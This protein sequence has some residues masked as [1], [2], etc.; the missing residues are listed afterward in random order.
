MQLK[1]WI[2]LLGAVVGTGGTAGLYFGLGVGW[3]SL[4]IVVA[5]V[6]VSYIIAAVAAAGSVSELEEFM[7]GF[8]VGLNTGVNSF[9]AY[10]LFNAIAGMEAGV[11][12][13]LILGVFN[14][15]CVVG[16]L[17]QTVV[18]QGIVG[19]ITWFMPMSWLVVALGLLFLLISLLLHAV[20]WGKVPYLKVQDARVDWKT[21]TIFIKGGLIANLNYLDTA[22]N[23]GN[24]S[25]VDYQS[26]DWH[27]DHEAGHTLNL[28]AFGS[29]FHL[30]GAVDENVIRR[31]ANAFSERIAESN[32]SGSGGNNIPMWS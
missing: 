24:F 28:T 18:Y 26:G 25:F 4:L 31:G 30:I 3:I 7:R 22:F 27:I 32:N 6:L 15:L 23:M 21:G 16:P 20:T 2:A 13:A 12:M 29:V 9:L 8:L 17:S 5:V 11:I 1:T 19:W 10:S 14:F